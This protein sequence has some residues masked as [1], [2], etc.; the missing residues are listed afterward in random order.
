MVHEAF[1]LEHRGRHSEA[2][3]LYDEALRV[4]P[5][6]ADARARR[7]HADLTRGLLQTV[8]REP[9]NLE[10]HVKLDHHLAQQRRFE[11]V[12]ALWNRFIARRPEE[13]RA[14]FE[15]G[16]ALFHNG[17]RELAFADLDKACTMGLA[18]ACATRDRIKGR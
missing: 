13:P 1:Q 2:V 15:R 16:G 14:Y 9:T 6:H 17:R 11:D 10:A 3:S 18:E 7:R 12:V 4:A 5:T 8:E